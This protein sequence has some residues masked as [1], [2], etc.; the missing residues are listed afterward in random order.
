MYLSVDKADPPRE[1][2]TGYRPS[3][4][5]SS[6][7]LRFVLYA[8]TAI[9]DLCALALGM[10][11]VAGLSQGL[12]AADL[13]LPLAFTV[14]I[15][16]ICGLFAG[17]YSHEALVALHVSW[18]RAFKGFAL[19]L[20][21]GMLVVGAIEQSVP[22]PPRAAW[23]GMALALVLVLAGRSAINIVVHRVL[24][25]PIISRV[26]VVDGTDLRDAPPGYTLLDCGSTDL[27]PSCND[28]V[29]LARIAAILSH[30]DQIVVSCPP[31]RRERWSV[32]LK[33]LGRDGGILVP[34]FGNL[35]MQY[36]SLAPGYPV[37][38]V[39]KGPLS[40]RN[41]V[42]KR[43]LDLAITVPILITLAIP[44]A[45]VALLIRLDSPGPVIFRQKRIGQH[46][47]MFEIFKFRSMRVESCDGEGARSTGRDD[48]RITTIGRFIRKTSIDEIPQLINVL[49]GDMSLVGPRPHAV[50]SRAQELLFWEIDNRYFLRHAIKPGITGLA[51]VQGYRGATERKE[52]LTHRLRADLAYSTQWSIWLDLAILLRTLR[53]LVHQNAY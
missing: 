13:W 26:Y 46:N 28:P 15:Y 42:M 34:E 51:Q 5:R 27:A 29:M 1:V 22:M 50:Q 52:D 53:V 44:M 41:R 40:L 38:L 8:V 36:S 7:K 25:R 23:A 49:L 21:L 11:F 3:N 48:D 2:V 4:L 30:T 35:G 17:A 24:A 9:T 39:S 10:F 45:I 16:V 19:T 18:S 14:P 47:H 31:E 6:A 37:V 32:V 12:H 43:A 20:L 33:G